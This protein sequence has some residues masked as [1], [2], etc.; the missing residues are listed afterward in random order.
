MFE[1]LKKIFILAICLGLVSDSYQT[2][3]TIDTIYELDLAARQHQTYEVTIPSDYLPDQNLYISA[4]S[5]INDPYEEPLMSIKS[6]HFSLDCSSDEADL[7]DVCF[8]TK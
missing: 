3:L 5:I 1:D 2:E 7:N 8:V 4:Y 6:S